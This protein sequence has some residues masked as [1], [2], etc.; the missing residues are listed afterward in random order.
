MKK[1]ISEYCES[2]LGDYFIAYNMAMIY[3]VEVK[4]Q[5]LNK[6]KLLSDNYK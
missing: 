3:N 4:P 5:E 6:Q 1:V 2:L